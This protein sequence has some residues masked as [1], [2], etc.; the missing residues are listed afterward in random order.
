MALLS[1][2][3]T[4][5]KHNRSALLRISQALRCLVSTL[6]EFRE[7]EAMLGSGCVAE[8]YQSRSHDRHSNDASP[9]FLGV[10]ASTLKEMVGKLVSDIE[11]KPEVQK[12]LVMIQKPVSG[13][14][15]E[16]GVLIQDA[17]I[18]KQPS[19]FVGT[20]PSG[21]GTEVHSRTVRSTVTCRHSCKLH[22]ELMDSNLWSKLPEELVQLVFARLPLVKIFD[23]CAQSS[24]WSTMSRTSNFRG[25]CSKRHLKLLGFVGV[26][27][28]L[29]IVWNSVY[30]IKSNKW[31]R[32][33][34]RGFPLTDD[35]RRWYFS[36]SV[37]LCDGGLLCLVP[38]EDLSSSPILVCNPLTDE[39]RV[40]PYLSNIDLYRYS[41]F[42]SKLVMEEDLTGYKVILVLTTTNLVHT[43]TILNDACA[44]YYNSKTGVWSCM[45]SG[46]VSG[47]LNNIY[48]SSGYP[49]VFDCATKTMEKCSN[50]QGHACAIVK[51]RLFELE[52]LG[53]DE[54]SFTVSEYTWQSSPA[55]CKK[56]NSTRPHSGFHLFAGGGYL[57]VFDENVNTVNQQHRFIHLYD[58]S[59][60]EWHRLSVGDEFSFDRLRGPALVGVTLEKP[61]GMSILPECYFIQVE[62]TLSYHSPTSW[63]YDEVSLSPPTSMSILKEA[64]P[65]V[66]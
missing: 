53:E 57:F 49:F 46:M 12:L 31:T 20:V 34:V 19:G 59:A 52:L 6:E 23:L 61:R 39:W 29:E 2:E 27:A 22:P 3:D 43:T 58:L 63:K 33:E 30:D 4:L 5:K 54:D 24:A 64:L 38:E 60:E 18:A 7:V 26:D 45:E 40:L 55:T 15:N 44:Y 9:E 37:L 48:G 16:S 65:S 56:I 50:L 13:A 66:P 14:A 51:D 36:S 35:L 1:L 11:A 10:V 8:A 28:D 47:F 32:R 62:V 21:R 41:D 25:V 42:M 17:T